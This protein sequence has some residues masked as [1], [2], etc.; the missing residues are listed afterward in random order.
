MI[1]VEGLSKYF[2]SIKAVDNLSFHVKPGEIV[3]L[4]GPNGAGKTTTMR[5]MCGITPASEGRVIIQGA[6]LADDPITAKR[7]LAFVPSEPRLFDYLTV[8]EHLGF[9]ARLYSAADSETRSLHRQK[10]QQSE[11]AGESLL[12]ELDLGDRA[13]YL[14]GALSRGMKQKLMIACAL[15]HEPK[16]LIFD[17]PF[18]GLDPHAIRKVR[19]IIQAHIAKGAAIIISSH[20]LGMVEDMI[21]NAIILSQGQMLVEGSLKEL[22]QRLSSEHQDADLEEIFIQLTSNNA[23]SP[24]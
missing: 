8:R 17:E 16:I 3:G 18:T 4:L 9:F 5:C 22:R 19:R 12:Q 21:S 2:G 15:I 7:E 11:Q 13:D 6:D 23:Q 10:V 20:L 24:A 14:P 1:Q